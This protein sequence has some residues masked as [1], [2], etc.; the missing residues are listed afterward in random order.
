MEYALIKNDIIENVIVA[1]I[2]FIETIQPN[3]DRIEEVDELK[4]QGFPI[5]V[6]ITW[7]MGEQPEEPVQVSAPPVARKVSRYAFRKRFTGTEKA[8]IELAAIDNP[9]AP[10]E[11][12]Q[13]AASLRATLKDQETASFID[14]DDTETIEGVNNLELVGLIATGR[15]EIILNTPVQ[16]SEKP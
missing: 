10:I 13:M 8:T 1:D 11:Q 5:G 4:A 3:Y 15:A 9:N 12:R 6:G 2:D 14:L 16:D 7:R